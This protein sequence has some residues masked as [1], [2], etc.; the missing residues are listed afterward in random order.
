MRTFNNKGGTNYAYLNTVRI[1][2]SQYPY[3]IGFGGSKVEFRLWIDGDNM[4]EN[5]YILPDDHTY[6][7]GYIIPNKKNNGKL[8]ISKIEAYGLG[9]P[10]ALAAQIEHR[11]MLK[12]L[13]DKKKQVDKKQFLDSDFDKEFLLG[14]TFSHKQEIE[15][16]GGS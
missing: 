7:V 3:G 15:D 11:E 2:N 1:E 5:S 6:E 12:K 13:R 14:G 8:S 4:I 10:E 9:G 16:R